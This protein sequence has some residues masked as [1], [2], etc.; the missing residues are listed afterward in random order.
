MAT[1][2]QI[3]EHLRKLAQRKERPRCDDDGMPY[4]ASCGNIDD[5][6]Q[7]GTEDGEIMLAQNL[8]ESLDNG[9][10]LPAL[11]DEDEDEDEDET[12]G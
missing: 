10:P 6:W 8:I 4:Y 3:I 5:A 9:A 12:G 2:T 7:I 11:P 1:E